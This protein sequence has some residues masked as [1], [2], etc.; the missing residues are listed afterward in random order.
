MY[1]YTHMNIYVCTYIHIYICI[2]IHTYEYTYWALGSLPHTFSFHTLFYYLDQVVDTLTE[3]NYVYDML[4]NT[5]N[6][7][8]RYND[9]GHI[10]TNPELQR[11]FWSAQSDTLKWMWDSIVRHVLKTVWKDLEVE[12]FDTAVPHD[13][14]IAT[15]YFF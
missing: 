10:G 9:T 3:C 5:I 12:D 15:W 14:V 6:M 2:Y 4:F 8:D 1:E 7:E 13:F 11:S